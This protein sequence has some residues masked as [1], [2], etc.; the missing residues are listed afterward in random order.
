MNTSTAV[1]LELTVR[2]AETDAMGI[3]H[4]SNYLVWFEA[5]RVAWMD[6]AGVP[7]T[8]VAASGHHFA[9]TG[10]AIQYRTPARFGDTVCVTAA[11]ERMRSRQVVFAYTVRNAADDTLLATGRTEHISVDLAGRMAS[12]PPALYE[13][14]LT[15]A[16]Q[17]RG[18]HD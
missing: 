13:R 9:V 14:L 15:G 4:H 6:A 1:T 16:E 17:L 3:V 12:I 8:E 5:A 11:V 10:V 7:Y 2:F 18:G